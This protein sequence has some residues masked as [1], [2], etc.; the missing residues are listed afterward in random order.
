[1]SLTDFPYRNPDYCG[2]RLRGWFQATLEL[3][4]CEITRSSHTACT[5]TGSPYCEWRFEWK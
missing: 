1:M 2:Q 3:S 4:W 5:S